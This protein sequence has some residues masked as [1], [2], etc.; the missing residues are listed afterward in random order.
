MVKSSAA[1]STADWQKNL[2]GASEKIRRRVERVTEAP[3]VAAAA[4]KEKML[5]KLIASIEDGTWERHVSNVSLSEWKASITGKGLRNLASGVDA[6]KGK[7][8]KAMGKILPAVQESQDKIKDMPSITLEDNI[9]RASEHMRNMAS[10]KG[11][12]GARD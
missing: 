6:A 2:K 12:L 3:G 10:K 11:T 4:A 8:E 5:A 1:E 7:M 9:A